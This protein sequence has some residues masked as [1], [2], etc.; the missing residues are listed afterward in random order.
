M[1][2]KRKPTDSTLRNVRATNKKIKIIMTLLVEHEKRL[3]R[4]EKKAGIKRDET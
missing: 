3:I 1:T 2:T 4:L